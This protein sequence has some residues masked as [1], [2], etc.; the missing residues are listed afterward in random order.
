MVE[1]LDKLHQEWR[2]LIMLLTLVSAI[3]NN[4][5]PCLLKAE[6]NKQPNCSLFDK[7]HPSRSV[8]LNGAMSVVVRNHEIA[9][10][11]LSGPSPFT[12]VSQAYIMQEE[13][14][15]TDEEWDA[16]DLPGERQM[17]AIANPERD[18]K[19][20]SI[21]EPHTESP[22]PYIVL[23]KGSSHWPLIKERGVVE[24]PIDFT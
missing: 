21:P 12:G 10:I 5:H 15:N 1:P 8:L 3:N 11:T 23:S 22:K 13:Q 4:G 9:A 19:K 7:S 18:T 24:V 17:T 16:I 14:V 2:T 6:R 20:A